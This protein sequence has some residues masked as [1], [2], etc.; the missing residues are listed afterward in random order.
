MLVFS[1]PHRRFVLTLDSN[2]HVNEAQMTL[3][4]V[5]YMYV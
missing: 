5:N 3:N 2:V 4:Q 1:Y